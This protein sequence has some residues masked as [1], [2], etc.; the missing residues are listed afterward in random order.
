LR[1]AKAQTAGLP[2][3]I[4]SHKDSADRHMSEQEKHTEK[5]NH[6]T[7]PGPTAPV[8]IAR[9]QAESRQVL[10]YCTRNDPGCSSFDRMRWENLASGAF[11]CEQMAGWHI[12]AR[13]KSLRDRP[14]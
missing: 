3:W 2:G 10:T 8:L 7:V 1:K 11:C 6:E 4:C 14:A 9:N 13:E 12:W 5:K